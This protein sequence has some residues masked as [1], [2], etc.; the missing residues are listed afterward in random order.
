MVTVL[1][2]YLCVRKKI[3]MTRKYDFP[4]IEDLHHYR[5]RITVGLGVE[6]QAVPVHL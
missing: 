6:G 4:Q 2:P 3:F 1:V 5:T